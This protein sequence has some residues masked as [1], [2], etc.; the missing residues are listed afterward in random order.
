VLLCGTSAGEIVTF[1]LPPGLV[2]SAALGGGT[3]AGVGGAAAAA[4]G[5]NLAPVFKSTFTAVSNGVHSITVPRQPTGDGSLVCFIGGGDGSIRCFVGMPQGGSNSGPGPGAGA[6]P[7]AHGPTQFSEQG[8]RT[9]MLQR[10]QYTAPGMGIASVGSLHWQCTGEAH[11]LGRVTSLSL[12]PSHTWFL[13]GTATGGLYQ[14]SFGLPLHRGLPPT[15]M[16]AAS[17]NGGPAPSVRQIE[18]S[19]TGAVLAAR[20]V[21]GASDAMVT[22]SADNSARVWNLNTFDSSWVHYPIGPAGVVPTCL[23]TDRPSVPATAAASSAGAQ[24]IAYP[25]GT[26]ASTAPAHMGAR[27]DG[28]GTRLQGNPQLVIPEPMTAR[29]KGGVHSSFPETASSV[30]ASGRGAAGPAALAA[31]S[32]LAMKPASCMPC[33]LYLGFSDGTLRCYDAVNPT[34]IDGRDSQ[35]SWRVTA[36]KGPVTAVAGNRAIIVTGGA[37]G[38]VCVWSRRGRDLLLQFSEHTKPVVTV[39]TDATSLENVYSVGQDRLLNTYNLRAERRVKSHTLPAEQQFGSATTTAMTCLTQNLD[40]RSESELFVGTTDGRIFCYDPDIP[41]MAIGVVDVAAMVPDY[42]GVLAQAA[43]GGAANFAGGTSN[44]PRGLMRPELRLN[45][46][47]CSPSGKYIAVVTQD[48]HIHVLLLGP[49]GTRAGAAHSALNN[50]AAGAANMPGGYG[51]GGG[52]VAGSVSSRIADMKL[53]ASHRGFSP[54]LDCTWSPDERQIIT[55]AQDA[56][57]S[58]WNWFGAE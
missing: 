7:Y 51:M 53:V 1:A 50:A 6:G 37:D 54:Y 28:T 40:P 5:G 8:A 10:S 39:A 33:Q 21:S 38:R 25:S 55:A 27:M 13:A 15:Y 58:V 3:T 20:F 16:R 47:R 2:N 49:S 11:T 26:I 56:C 44:L 14:V 4:G 42:G 31:A 32:A 23:W 22:V 35:E 29:R 19:H 17:V 36:H 57:V 12:S 18:V 48:G 45:A 43:R 41:N 30:L 34:T 9:L 46:V 52:M 24:G